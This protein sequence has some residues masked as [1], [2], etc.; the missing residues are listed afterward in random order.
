MPVLFR[1]TV[2]CPH[3]PEQRHQIDTTTEVARRVAT[4]A[5]DEHIAQ[6]HPATGGWID[7]ADA[8]SIGEST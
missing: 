3:C 2:Q 6:E 1:V 7:R 4:E 8:P 5:M